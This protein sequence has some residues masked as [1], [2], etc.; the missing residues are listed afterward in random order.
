MNA[1]RSVLMERVRWLN[2]TKL[3]SSRKK[4]TNEV[5]EQ[6]PY[7]SLPETPAVELV[8]DQ[9]KHPSIGW[10]VFGL[11]AWLVLCFGASG[12]GSSFTIPEINGWFATLEKPSF[13]PPNWLF[14][15]VWSVLFLMM[16]V[17]AWLVWRR[18]R[19]AGA[20]AAIT[21]FIVQLIANVM[22][23]VLFFG[24]HSP[25]MAFGC[26]CVLWLLIA[27]TIMLFWKKSPLAGAL[28][29]PYLAWVTFASVLNFSIWQLN[30]G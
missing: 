29:V 17:S 27:I 30:M 21:A 4:V 25:S 19:F 23:S 5:S 9:V 18:F 28:L 15:P 20:P 6:N 2:K 22:W 24:L 12:I 26:I 1:Q 10:Q 16:A 13:N 7:E 3:E 11:V 14:G 8:P